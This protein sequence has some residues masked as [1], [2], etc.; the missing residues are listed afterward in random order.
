MS[1][2]I[3]L[4]FVWHM[5]Q[6]FYKDLVSGEYK[7]PWARMHALKDYY[8]M[9]KVLDDFPDIH[10]TFN[11]VP[12]MLVQVDDYAKGTAGDPF[13]RAAMKP[14]EELLPSEKEFLLGY[15]FQASDQL[16]RRY[17][18]YL[19][20]HQV[21]QRSQGNPHFAAGR[22][23][24][25]MFRDL[26]VLSQLAWFDEEYLE[27]DSALAD[28]VPK[29]RN[30][31]REDQTLLAAKEQEACSKVIPVYEEFA[32]RGQIEL[33]VTPFYHPILPLICDTSI[34]GVAH[35]YVSLP[36]R[37]NYPQDAS[38]QLERSRAYFEKRFGVAPAG[39]WPSEGSVSDEVLSIA[40]DLGFQWTATDNGILLRTLSTPAVPVVSYQPFRWQQ[41]GKEIH[42]V[43]RDHF[44]SDLIGFVY[45]RMHAPAAAEHFIREIKNNCE[46]IITQNRDALVPIILDGENAW[47]YYEQSGRPFLKYLYGL[48]QDDP[49]FSAVTVSEALQRIPASPIGR[50]FPGSWINANFDVWVGAEEDNK[51]WSYLLAAR[52][53][54]DE[55]VNSDKGHAL[56]DIAK[57]MAWEELLISEGSDWCWWYGPEHSSANRPDFDQLYREHLA[58]VYRLLAQP[59]PT[60]LSRPIL[61]AVVSSEHDPPSGVIKAV[62]DGAVTSYFEWLGSGIYR[63]DHRSGA[64]HS[65]QQLISEL[66]YG[67]DG[68]QIFLRM[69]FTEPLIDGYEVEFRMQLR[70]ASQE[71]FFVTHCW[72]NHRLDFQGSNISDSA[73]SVALGSIYEAAISMADLHVRYGDSIWISLAIFRNGLPVAALPLAGEIEVNTSEPSAWVF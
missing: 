65:H 51:A 22:F 70:N 37:F 55:I 42:V 52:Q 7:L 56:P 63:M 35:P 20:L 50:I 5:H 21:L 8:G 69:D 11:L 36:P 71:E 61:S 27:N 26:Q 40:A 3:Y 41:S 17:P 28:L 39:L 14:A 32:R 67:S 13:L 1:G 12:S 46:P 6:P 43:F 72:R 2:H 66:R 48:V 18:R 68:R 45:S 53:T 62:I 10:Q 19:E 4:C 73:I 44:L 16:I 34:A 15:F 9:V 47:E 59:V 60:E 33:S 49:Q 30:Y 23:D 29:G 38:H 24:T 25:Q 31:S 57:E 58:N 54:Y 64:M